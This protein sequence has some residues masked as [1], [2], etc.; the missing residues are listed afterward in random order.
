[1][2]KTWVGT[3]QNWIL[4]WPLN[5]EKPIKTSVR[6]C[7]SAYAEMAKHMP[8]SCGGEGVEELA[9]SSASR[10]INEKLNICFTILTL[11]IYI[12][13]AY[14]HI[15]NHHVVYKIIIP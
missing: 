13:K 12:I 1:M 4:K 10:Y 7:Y 15:S 9:P 14:I 11:S 2:K 8:I 6:K 5:K 3:S